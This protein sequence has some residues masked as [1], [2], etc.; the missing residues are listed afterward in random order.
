[1][2]KYILDLSNSSLEN[3]QCIDTL[4]HIFKLMNLIIDRCPSDELSDDFHIM[5]N[6][7]LGENLLLH[8]HDKLI[9][10]R[11]PLN[12]ENLFHRLESI[13]IGTDQDH[14]L[15]V[16]RLLNLHSWKSAIFG[17][18][19]THN[20]DISNALTESIAHDPFVLLTNNISPPSDLSNFFVLVF[21]ALATNVILLKNFVP[22]C[23]YIIKDKQTTIDQDECSLYINNYNLH[24]NYITFIHTCLH[25][26]SSN[27][28]SLKH[29]CRHLIRQSFQ[30]HII[31]KIEKC[32]DLNFEH[33]DYLQLNELLLIDSKTHDLLSIIHLIK[34]LVSY[35]SQIKSVF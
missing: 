6:N 2:C 34:R 35:I 14:C 16:E 29:L 22:M 4:E 23:K 10:V 8:L 28:F 9:D 17:L 25:Y 32:S 20:V 19:N 1:M 33:R 13:I 24:T 11:I 3:N 15:F 26:A 12:T 27:V 5:K 21:Y 31:D 30:S 7:K 18:C